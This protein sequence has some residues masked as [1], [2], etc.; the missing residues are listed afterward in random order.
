MLSSN[1]ID[2][3]IITRFKFILN[4]LLKSGIIQ[5]TT[6]EVVVPRKLLRLVEY[7]SEGTLHCRTSQKFCSCEQVKV[8]GNFIVHIRFHRRHSQVKIHYKVT[9]LVSVS[10]RQAQKIII[11]SSTRFF[12]ELLFFASNFCTVLLKRCDGLEEGTFLLFEPENCIGNVFN[13]SGLVTYTFLLYLLLYPLHHV[14]CVLLQNT[15]FSF[16][17]HLERTTVLLSEQRQAGL[18]TMDI[19]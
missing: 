9:R 10:C 12:F 5:V 11:S 16:Y 4:V 15:V 13:Y 8:L 2:R 7:F 3:V 14:H 6:L 17:L 1:T 19:Y 18:N